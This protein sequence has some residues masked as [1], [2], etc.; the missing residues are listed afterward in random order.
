M[1]TI[2]CRSDPRLAGELGLAQLELA[3]SVA[4]GQTE[5]QGGS[6][7]HGGPDVVERQQC[8]HVVEQRQG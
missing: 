1:A 4:D 8:T 7:L 5:V 3:A 2:H 6:D